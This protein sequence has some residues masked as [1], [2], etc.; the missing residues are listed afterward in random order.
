MRERERCKT[1]LRHRII[2]GIQCC[3]FCGAALLT[4]YCVYIVYL[5]APRNIFLGVVVQWRTLLL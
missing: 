3:V 5:S 4:L 2:N 1:D